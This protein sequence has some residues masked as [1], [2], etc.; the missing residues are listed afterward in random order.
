MPSTRYLCG[1]QGAFELQK[2]QPGYTSKLPFMP[3][4]F[5]RTREKAVD[6][7]DTNRRCI[8]IFRYC[9]HHGRF[10][11]TGAI[12]PKVTPQLETITTR[13]PTPTLPHLDSCNV[14]LKM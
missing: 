14:I 11:M 12:Y 2:L 4:V 7:A 8:E 13:Y 1:L 3:L 10:G 6:F 5:R 9:P